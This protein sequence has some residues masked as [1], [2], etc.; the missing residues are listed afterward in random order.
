MDCPGFWC[1][2]VVVQTQTLQI[3][4]SCLKNKPKQ[5]DVLQYVR[6][7]TLL[8]VGMVQVVC[9]KNW[10]YT[11]S[12]TSYDSAER[13]QLSKHCSNSYALTLQKDA[14]AVFSFS[15]RASLAKN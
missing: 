14:G 7:K 3:S 9:L 11:Y 12:R 6:E 4:Q 5:Q 1:L 10:V 8:N 13:C 15:L 2:L